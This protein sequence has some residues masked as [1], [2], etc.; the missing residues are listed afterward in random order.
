MPLSVTR[1]F[2]LRWSLTLS[3][4][5]EPSSASVSPTAPLI[6]ITS[7]MPLPSLSLRAL[8]FFAGLAGE[9]VGVAVAVVGSFA[10]TFCGAADDPQ[11]AATT[12]RVPR[13]SAAILGSGGVIA[14]ASPLRGRVS[15]GRLPRSLVVPRASD[16]RRA[17]SPCGQ[18][19]RPDDVLRVGLRG[20]RVR[21]HDDGVHDRN[22]LVRRHPRA[23]GLL[24][25]LLGARA[26]VDA[27]RAE[28]PIRLLHDV[29]ADP[30]DVVGHLLPHFGG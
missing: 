25:H 6:V 11:P 13:E 30:A 22:D 15:V 27:D 8:A 19:S 9:A 26:L 29:R 21:V 2:V 23:L 24:T 10:A 17:G 16:R 12:A 7:G 20:H 1:I 14:P 4:R 3:L 18:R 28:L 5:P